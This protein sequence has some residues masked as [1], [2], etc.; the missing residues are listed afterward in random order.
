MQHFTRKAFTLVELLIVI[1]II[2]ILAVTLMVSLNPVEAQRKA[3]DTQRL[4]DVSTLQSVLEQAI[5]DGLAVCGALCRSSG[6]T[7]TQFS[8]SSN[9][10]G[11]NVCNYAR[12]IPADPQNNRTASCTNDAGVRSNACMMAYYVMVSGADYEINVRQESTTNAA[13]VGNDGGNNIYMVEMFTGSNA[14]I[15]AAQNP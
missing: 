1:G 11:V 14:L 10:L 7:T 6:T 2:G 15:S 8:C 5:N 9:W 12:T 3:R 4:K 13:K